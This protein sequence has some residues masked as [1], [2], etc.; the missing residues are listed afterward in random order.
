[1]GSGN[2]KSW[3]RSAEPSAANRSIRSFVNSCTRGANSAN[4]R[5]VNA[6]LTSRR[7]RVWSG[8]SMFS[9]CVI[10]S[11]L[12]SP[13]IPVLPFACAG[14]SWCAGFLESRGS[15]SACLASAYRV[16]SQ[17]S[18]PLGNRVLCTGSCSRSQA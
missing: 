9:R 2:A 15:A 12:R 10:N 3:M 5:G 1:M 6:L 7:N 16:T 13:G 17:A 11:A 4:R 8:G 18:T 14:S